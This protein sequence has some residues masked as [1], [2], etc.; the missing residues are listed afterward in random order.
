MLRV[1]EAGA[2]RTA[3]GAEI[4]LQKARFRDRHA[5]KIAGFLEPSFL[6]KV[7]SWL[8]AATFAPKSHEGIGSELVCW[9]SPAADALLFVVND[10]AVFKLITE[11]TGVGPIGCFLGRIYRMTAESAHHEFWHSDVG[12]HRLLALSVNLGEEPY[13]GGVTVLREQGKPATE[14]V[15]ENTT[16]GDALLF[17]IDEALEHTLTDVEPGPPKTAWAGWFRSQPSFRDVLAGK[18]KL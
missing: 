16:P 4:A 12:D 7:Q 5:V 2:A 8:R 18:A 1:G 9:N 13:R 10:P 15:L 17:R 14:Q 3:D 6:A 11:V